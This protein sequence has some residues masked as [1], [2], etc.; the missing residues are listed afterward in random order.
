MS[1]PLDKI[2]K[3]IGLVLRK[4]IPGQETVDL[5]KLLARYVRRERGKPN[6]FRIRR[7][8]T[9]ELGADASLPPLRVREA[10]LG[11]VGGGGIVI[12]C[13]PNHVQG[14]QYALKVT[15]PSLFDDP[16]TAPQEFDATIGEYLKHAPLSHQNV[17]R[18]FFGT[19]LKVLVSKIAA[20]EAYKNCPMMLMEWLRSPQPLGRWLLERAKDPR[21]VLRVLIEVF[22]G[23][24]HLHGNKLAHWDLKSDNILVDERG[25]PKLVD[26]GNSR[27][28][29]G[30]GAESVKVQTTEWNLPAELAAQVPRGEQKHDSKRITMEVPAAW[31]RPATDIF[32]LGKELERL[33]W[34]PP[35]ATDTSEDK[36]RRDIDPKQVVAMLNRCF[37]P[38]DA[39]AQFL[40]VCIRFVVKRMLRGD[41]LGDKVFYVSA[42]EVVRDLQKIL[43]AFGGADGV[44]ELQSIPQQVMRIPCWGNLAFTPRVSRL[45]NCAPVRRLRKH[46]QLAT[47]LHVYPG[48]TH[49]RSEHMAGVMAATA[50]YI[51]ALYADRTN[52]FW[53]ISVETKDVSALLLAAVLHDLGH[54][55]FGHFLEEMEGVFRGHMHED[56]VIA[57]LDPARVGVFAG[58]VSVET[59]RKALLEVAQ[60]WVSDQQTPAELLTMV[61]EIIAPCGKTSTAA[62]STPGGVFDRIAAAELKAQILHTII[63]SS[64]D[65]DK[66]D[67]LMRDSHHCGVKYGAG[68]DAERFF[69]SLT[70]ITHVPREYL[71]Q[72]TRKKIGACIGV[73]AKGVLP[74]ESILLARFQM[75]GAVYWQHTARAE[76][77]MLQFLVER[78]LGL[79]L[80]DEVEK[81]FHSLLE[82]FRD[83]DDAMALDWLRRQVE[84]SDALGPEERKRLVR[85]AQALIE[86]DGLYWKA[87]ELEFERISETSAVEPS[88]KTVSIFA[89]YMKLLADHAVGATAPKMKDRLKE[90]GRLRRATTAE[91]ARRVRDNGTDKHLDVFDG[92]VL[93]DRAPVGKDQVENIFVVSDGN[94]QAIQDVSA[95]ADAIRQT[96]GYWARKLRVFLAPDLVRRCAEA[97][98]EWMRLQQIAKESLESPLQQEF[99]LLSDRTSTKAVKDMARGSR[100]KN[101]PKQ[102]V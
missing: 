24:S 29:A 88:N 57:V 7:A 85:V 6:V 61:A 53:R 98:I 71:E 20:D 38:D 8:F 39:D 51:R 17:V 77:A 80:A 31:N 44:P 34:V 73:R 102:E 82:M 21:D 16:A 30:G 99:R 4:L 70:T 15:R 96:F 79:A 14:V 19:N 2:A 5:T 43:P 40:L 11:F 55:A 12:Q 100:T 90:V 49:R 68:I 26:L 46:H 83:A 93:V 41:R 89:L 95:I 64:I 58:T 97:G 3:D 75:F 74:V 76:T 22:Q 45:F 36:G 42:D 62:V 91:F 66:L 65:A 94:V 18:V 52:P 13:E 54:V 69:Q 33:F 63:D 84:S 35:A 60:D 87:Y 25:V 9:M 72:P 59:D 48:A 81:R 37:Q 86:R 32:M 23:L 67:Y 92:E 56:Y 28:I 1:Q 27:R 101:A 10:A 50:N 47:I 78:Y